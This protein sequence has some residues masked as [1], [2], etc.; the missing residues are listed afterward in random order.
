MA[1]ADP[2]GWRSFAPS[3]KP[4]DLP[5]FP[6]LRIYLCLIVLL[7]S[8][9][10]ARV[11]ADWRDE[12]GYTRLKLLADSDLPGAPSQ[13][14]CQVE[15]LEN[16]AN[17]LP[18]TTSV[19]FTG[20]TFTNKSGSSGISS[21]ATHVATNFY[22]NTTSLITGNCPVDLYD[23][24]GWLG[25]L[26]LNFGTGSQPLTQSRSVEN[27]S[28]VADITGVT[29]AQ[30]T[31]INRRLDFAINRDGFVCVVGSD[32]NGSTTLPQI[33][34]Q[35][36]NTISV[37][38]DDGG[39]SAGF[40]HLDGSGRIKPDIV[41][42]SASPEYATSWTTP[43]VSSAAALLRA[44]IGTTLSGAHLPRVIKAL[45]LASAIKN[46]S[47]INTATQPLDSRYGAG[48]A[49]INHAYNALK[50]GR[51]TASTTSL[52]NARGWAAESVSSSTPKTYYFNIP[53]GAASTPFSAALT[54][55]RVVADG[56]GGPTWGNPTSS[57][58]NLSLHLYN[59]N[60]FTLGSQIAGSDSAV[61]NVELIYQAAL[62]PGSYAL[63]V[64]NP[65]TTLTDYALAW[66]SLPSVTLAATTPTAREIDGQ[67]GLITFTRTGDTALPL[68]V[69]L[70][71]SGSAVSGSH[72]LTL[73]ASVTIPAGQASTTL[74][75]IPVSDNL[76][77]G[78]RTVVVNVAADFALVHDAAQTATVTIQDKP[79]DHW[80]FTNFTTSELGAPAISGET[81]DPDADNL[82]N[83]V[84]YAL[85]LP[86]KFSNTSPVAMTELSGY[87]AISVAK[88]PSATDITW[89]AET[90]ANLT[91]WQP[92][93][94]TVNTAST[95]E[96]RDS[97]LKNT[98]PKRFIRLKITRP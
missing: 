38:R 8:I 52:Q 49:N 80:R 3:T 64:Q 23:A 58:A 55:H 46:S 20:K 50:A 5:K 54:W 95:F 94:T 36:Y 56:I 70:A 32:N 48:I 25:S 47:W 81:A 11:S 75:I 91:I 14:F 18:G 90:S 98:A 85:G 31:E 97:V 53:T 60:G 72:F 37:G 33:L 69:P 22:G 41:A 62:A 61:D 26:F 65:A 63:V 68:F 19:L 34:S 84:E 78:P 29:D 39:H 77:Q 16:N 82:A 15:A 9:G 44:K 13:G 12:I 27:H 28:W 45:L 42:P 17:F 79:F 93:I 96:A 83:L 24:S 66:H 89:S 6:K 74:P 87:L 1:L 76:A 86:P 7:S 67:S 4:T 88:S 51:G 43:M 59:A 73:P 57:L 2:R 71:V 30:A 10:I 21:H 92:A 35:S 40:T